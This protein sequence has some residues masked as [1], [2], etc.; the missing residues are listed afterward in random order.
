MAHGPRRGDAYGLHHASTLSRRIASRGSPDRPV[1]MQTIRIN[2]ST[3]RLRIVEPCV[4]RTAAWGPPPRCSPYASRRESA[5]PARHEAAAGAR[6]QSSVSPQ[7]FQPGSPG[8]IAIGGSGAAGTAPSPAPAGAPSAGLRRRPLLGRGDGPTST[9]SSFRTGVRSMT[10]WRGTLAGGG[11]PSLGAST[12]AG[13]AS[14]QPRISL[15]RKGLRSR[16]R[17]Q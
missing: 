15:P 8:L 4:A 5:S 1:V 6:D 2:P 7:R 10:T 9:N 16:S 14:Q 17:P 12:N 3:V 11:A 13:A